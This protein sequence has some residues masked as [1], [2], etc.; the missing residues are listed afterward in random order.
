LKRDDRAE[1]LLPPFVGHSAA[2]WSAVLAVGRR[3]G[4][5]SVERYRLA[6]RA[7]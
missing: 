3:G 5:H 7:V 2:G 4:R 1:A 6:M